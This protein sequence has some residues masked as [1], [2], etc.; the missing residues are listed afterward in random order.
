MAMK[1]ELKILVVDDEKTNLKILSELLT[2]YYKVVLAKNGEDALKR[3]N[4]ELP[5]DLILLDV[6]MPDVDGYETCQRLKSNKKTHEIPIIFLT[7]KTEPEEVVR[8]FEIGAV[9]YITKPFNPTELLSRIRTHLEL[10]I[11]RETIAKQNNEFKELL[12]VL[13][14]DLKNPVGALQSLME[15]LKGDI[16][17][18]N[19]LE[20]MIDLS[21]TNSLDIIEQVREMQAITEKG[22]LVASSCI[23]LC[24]LVEESKNILHYKLEQKSIEIDYDIDRSLDIWAEK[25]SFVNSVLN[26]ILTNAIKFSFPDSKILI[27]AEKAEDLVTVSIR[28]FGIGIPNSIL[29]NLF[30][31]ETRYAL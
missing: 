19:N 6:I 22:A 5:P 31:S 23:N 7:A 1:N 29:K 27:K 12:H 24:E 17:S 18:F 20:K 15:L 11:G 30:A 14:H 10:K 8:G 25:T 16:S 21:I 28:D 3:A 13:C 2:P 4:N 26:N 9:D